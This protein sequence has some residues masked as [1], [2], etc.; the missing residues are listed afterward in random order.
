MK[1]ILIL[2]QLAQTTD[3]RVTATRTSYDTASRDASVLDDVMD[4]DADDDW[5]LSS[6]LSS[7]SDDEPESDDMDVDI[8]GE[9][10]SDDMDV[11]V[12]MWSSGDEDVEMV[13]VTSDSSV[14]PWLL[15][16]LVFQSHGLWPRS[17]PS[18]SAT[19]PSLQPAIRGM[20]TSFHTI[21]DG[22]NI[23]L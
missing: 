12:D 22:S 21:K 15:N 20:A 17:R 2:I 14:V 11:D 9:P 6:P 16:T 7:S 10:E 4:V 23:A 3:I 13:D 5:E 8:D 19:D 1:S 18:V